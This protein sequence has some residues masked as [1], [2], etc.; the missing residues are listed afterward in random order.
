MS[1]A[2]GKKGGSPKK[3]KKQLEEEALRAREE[4]RR[5]GDS[6]DLML[7]SILWYPEAEAGKIRQMS[8]RLTAD[9]EA[10]M[11]LD[12]EREKGK[13]EKVGAIGCTA[14]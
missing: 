5:G 3:S 4:A 9:A 11:G 13:R 7:G 14:R 10:R 12:R 8:A 6:T 2:M 1:V